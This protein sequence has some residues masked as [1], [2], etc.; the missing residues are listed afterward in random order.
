MVVFWSKFLGG[1]LQIKTKS[2]TKPKPKTNWS[3][4]IGAGSGVRTNGEKGFSFPLRPGTTKIYVRDSI[5][6]SSMSMLCRQSQQKVITT[7]FVFGIFK[8]LTTRHSAA[9][10][11]HWFRKS[12]HIFD[13]I[14]AENSHNRS[15]SRGR[16]PIKA[17]SIKHRNQ[18][19]SNQCHWCNFC[20]SDFRT[21]IPPNSANHR[22]NRPWRPAEC[23]K[24]RRT[25]TSG[26]KRTL[27]S[28]R[29]QLTCHC[30]PRCV[31][32]DGQ[33]GLGV[34]AWASG[35]GADL[36]ARHTRHGF[37]ESADEERRWRGCRR[38][39]KHTKWVTRPVLLLCCCS[40]FNG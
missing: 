3:Y 1:A 28:V 29:H 17:R 20:A 18:N 32:C 25:W 2:V 11:K 36:T 15:K 24:R 10:P 6:W 33:T 13:Q 5:L 14:K 30:G 38:T 23:R 27:L 22:S 7:N 4:T 39:A 8:T 40:M 31:R 34:R 37:G 16:S 35:S 26:R 21:K 12:G 9:I 19:K